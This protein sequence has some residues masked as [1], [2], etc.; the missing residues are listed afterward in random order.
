MKRLSKYV[1]FLTPLMLVACGGT[2]DGAAPATP[3]DGIRDVRVEIPAPE[4]NYIDFIGSEEVIQP[5]TEKMTCI[6]FQYDGEDAAFSQQLALQGKFGHHAVLLSAK[7]PLPPGTVEDCTDAA[8]MANFDPFTVSTDD[9]PEGYGTYLPKGKQMVLQTHYLNTSTTPIRTR[10]VVRLKMVPID[11]VKK[12]VSMFVTGSLKIE[13]PAHQVSELQFDCTMPADVRLILLGGHM[14]EWG[15]KFEAFMGPNST[16]MESLYAVDPW[17]SEFRDNPPVNLY[18]EN[19]MPIA[20]GTVLR[21]YCQYNNT[22]PD[23]LDFPKEMCSL[24]S[25]VEGSKEPIACVDGN[26]GGL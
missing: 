1:L 22:T 11:S 15:T 6:H 14:H 20:K 26:D 9:M 19:P 21:T 24:F 13:M 5:G 7:K 10:D 25:L 3:D 8:S 16:A 23:A 12:W 18:F 17:N 4:A 2:D